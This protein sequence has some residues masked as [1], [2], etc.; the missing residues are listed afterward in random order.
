MQ[1]ILFTSVIIIILFTF[2]AAAEIEV[3][4]LYT[5]S[6]NSLNYVVNIA[7]NDVEVYSENDLQTII[8]TINLDDPRICDYDDEN[9]IL[10]VGCGLSKKVYKLGFPNLNYIDDIQL[11]YEV[12]AITVVENLGILYVGT[13][14][15]P[16]TSG[17]WHVI[18]APINKG[19]LCSISLDEFEVI[20]TKNINTLPQDIIYNDDYSKLYVSCNEEV[21]TDNGTLTT[22]S[23][24]QIL[25]IEPNSLDIQSYI[26]TPEL[27]IN[28]IKGPEGYLYTGSRWENYYFDNE[29]I[30]GV[31]LIEFQLDSSLGAMK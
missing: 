15:W 14:E 6:C 1:I 24:Y 25:I 23:G 17:S 13:S 20:T 2:P 12:W 3:Y 9:N 28:V 10:Y 18:Y 30:D 7:S 4:R 5:Y 27:G 16:D 8:Y 19:W 11:D 22:G 21:F 29:Y 31:G 26:H